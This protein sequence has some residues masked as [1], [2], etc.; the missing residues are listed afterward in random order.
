MHIRLAA[1]LRYRFMQSELT[2]KITYKIIPPSD[3]DAAKKLIA[4]A[5]IDYPYFTALFDKLNKSDPAAN[6]PSQAAPT[7]NAP[8]QAAP[9]RTLEIMQTSRAYKALLAIASMN[10]WNA[11]KCGAA[12][13]GYI[14]G[15]L[16]CAGL[17]CDGSKSNKNLFG[18]LGAGG[19]SLIRYAGIK[20]TRMAIDFDKQGQNGFYKTEQT[21]RKPYWYMP[22]LAV[23]RDMQGGGIGSAFISEGLIPYLRTQQAN[24][25]ILF[26]NT[27]R[28]FKFYEKNG[29]S[30][31]C[32]DTLKSHGARV[33]C[34]NFVY[35]L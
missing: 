22:Y 10:I 33:S 16:I 30:L 2:N 7:T 9:T 25:F 5:F 28:D 1:G 19:I 18:M 8:S 14:D 21:L 35:R 29:F 6:A 27:D 34:W 32:S 4:N 3:Y 17:L 26:T 24:D 15:R 20:I 23:A 13:G 31:L 12:Y 11:A